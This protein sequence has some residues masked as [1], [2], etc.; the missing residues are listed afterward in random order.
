MKRKQICLPREFKKYFWDVD[1]SKIS[2]HPFSKFVLERI[3]N[4]GDLKALKW[5]LT[6]VPKKAIKEVV[7]KSREL[8]LKTRNF[9]RVVYGK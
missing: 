4:F 7:A 1:F 6:V 3:M 8:E 2:S 5:M 9:W